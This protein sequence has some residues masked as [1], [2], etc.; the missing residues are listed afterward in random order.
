MGDCEY[1]DWFC[2]PCTEEI[3][4]FSENKEVSTHQLIKIKIQ[5]NLKLIQTAAHALNK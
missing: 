5:L 2:S 1:G 3:F 4:P